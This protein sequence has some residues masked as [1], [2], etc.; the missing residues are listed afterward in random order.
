MPIANVQGEILR[1]GMHQLTFEMMIPVEAE[2]SSSWGDG[3]NKLDVTHEVS[4]VVE[5]HG[6][7][8]SS[9]M[10]PQEGFYE[11]HTVL[12][13]VAR[14][15][16]PP[17]PP[18]KFDTQERVAYCCL[19]KQG[20]ISLQADLAKSQFLAGE[21]MSFN[22]S[23][24]NN[25][26][27]SEAD[28]VSSGTNIQVVR[29]VHVSAMNH[30]HGSEEVITSVPVQMMYTGKSAQH[31]VLIPESATSSLHFGE[32]GT[33]PSIRIKQKKTR[34]DAGIFQTGISSILQTGISY[35]AR[36]EVN[37]PTCI[38][39]PI[40][41]LPINIVRV[42]QFAVAVYAP[43]PSIEYEIDPDYG[44]SGTNQYAPPQYGQAARYQPETKYQDFSHKDL[45]FRTSVQYVGYEPSAPAAP[46]PPPP[47]PYVPHPWRAI[48]S[49]DGAG[50]Y[51]F[52]N[53]ETD[54][55]TWDKPA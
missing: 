20:T 51:Y 40:L 8:W 19:F 26:S 16:P 28:L 54:E 18:V 32:E 25:S 38:D 37:T 9:E 41:D 24:T 17:S 44:D 11:V 15:P 7:S 48:L 31:K 23:V 22:A 3:R 42:P 33:R 2:P 47:A 6:D 49:P 27:V 21:N 29:H 52:H 13:D 55:T 50:D 1:G 5:R 39:N 34:S 14:P 10:G 53:T 45:D 35:T 36:L 12:L 46:L 43:D 30:Q 4:V